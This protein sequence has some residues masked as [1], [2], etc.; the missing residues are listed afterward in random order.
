MPHQYVSSYTP[1]ERVVLVGII[2]QNQP[3]EK[4]KE[5]LDELTFLADTAGMQVMHRFTQKLERPDN[6]FFIGSGKLA[7]IA[8]YVK[9]K[10]IQGIIFDDELSPSQQRNLE[11]ELNITIHD[12]TTLILKIFASRA[13]SATAK[14]Q[15][16]LAQLQYLMPRLARMW[17]HLDRIKGGIGM[18]G[19]G[20]KEIE[21][22][23]RIIRDKIALLKEQLRQIDR[24]KLTQRGNRGEM[25]RVSMAG[26]TNA[27]KST[28]MNLL[29]KAGVFAENKLFATLDTTVRKVVIR[30]LPFLLSDTVG[31]IRK[32]PTQLVESFKSTLDEICEADIILHVVDVSNES[33]EDHMNT[34]KQ[35]LQEIGAGNKP[36]ILVFNKVDAYTYHEDV[37]DLTR[38]QPS[39]E[40]LQNTWLGKSNAPCVFIS[41]EKKYHIEALKDILYHHVYAIHSKRYPHNTGRG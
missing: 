27:G 41:A 26:Y 20:E 30:E 6:R 31:F 25:V 24:Q 32:L 2:T 4:L 9:E 13:R 15:V 34:V 14:K 21:T 39:L 19:A 22:D 11:K 1:P 29:S 16:E 7:Q 36:A 23:R 38:T 12:R 5:Y 37:H 28:L 18:K 35:T 17:S 33:F 8:A 40:E 10:E 3:E